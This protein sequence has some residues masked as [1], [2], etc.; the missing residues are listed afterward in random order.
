MPVNIF[1]HIISVG[2]KGLKIDD[3][4]MGDSPRSNKV[5]LKSSSTNRSVR[6]AYLSIIMM[7]ILLIPLSFQSA[8][9]YASVFI[10]IGAAQCPAPRHVQ[11]T[12]PTGNRIA[13]S[14]H[15]HTIQSFHILCIHWKSKWY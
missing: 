12:Y 5:F 2:L 14:L 3:A 11:Y 1:Y 13:Q 15:M 9:I 7:S 4:S 8:S 10:K 6:S